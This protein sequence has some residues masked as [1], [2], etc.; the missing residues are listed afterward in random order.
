MTELLLAALERLPP[1]A[2]RFVVAAGVLLAL[3]AA[4]AALTL[5]TPQD[6]R[7]RRPSPRPPVATSSP[8]TLPRRPRPPVSSGALIQ[9]RQVAE[10]FLA[11]YLPFAY[12][13]GGALDAM[14]VTPT[15]RSQLRRERAQ[16]TPLER[17]RQP[18]VVSLRT[19]ATTPTFVI[20]T[21][22]IDDGG[23]ATY[24]LRF[25]VNHSAGRWAVSSV[26]EG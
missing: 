2:R 10:S 11:G 9:V 26:E 18:H 13:R 8:L 3:G 23:V 5:T 12:G 4:M 17:R 21:A 25:T 7:R 20:A 22:V 6:S 19:I 14:G 24:R 1:R 16:P 15:L